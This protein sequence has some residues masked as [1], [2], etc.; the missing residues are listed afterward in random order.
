MQ[1][2]NSKKI[3]IIGSGD[4][5]QSIAWYAKQNGFVVAGFFDDYQYIGEM[6]VGGKILGKLSD[7]PNLFKAGLY[8]ELVCGIGYKHFKSRE[9]LFNLYHRVYNIPFA[10]IIDKTCLVDSS[11]TIGEGC[12]LF[13][14]SLVDKGVVLGENVLLNVGVTIAHDSIIKSHSFIC[15][16][17]AVAG[18]ST[19]GSRCMIGINTTI[20]DKINIADDIRTAGGAVVTMNL[21]D[22]GLYAGVPAVWKKQ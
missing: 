16:R 7:I 15:P 13:P 8:D 18:F 1:Q 14:G 12:V 19:I 6:T 20:I 3:A 9:E 22:K 2:N 4:L 21:N 11:S 5:G 10:T 17:V